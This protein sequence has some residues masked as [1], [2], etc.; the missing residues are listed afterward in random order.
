LDALLEEARVV[1]C[2]MR[3]VVLPPPGRLEVV[4]L[5]FLVAPSVL[6]GKIERALVR[7][8]GMGLELGVDGAP[9]VTKTVVV[10]VWKGGHVAWAVTVVVASG[11][12]G[13]GVVVVLGRTTTLLLLVTT[14]VKLEE[15]REKVVE[16]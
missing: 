11:Q 10:T 3:I 2:V 12:V 4:V 16:K 13:F 5:T 14:V 7:V 9:I 8:A 1:V 6:T 15:K